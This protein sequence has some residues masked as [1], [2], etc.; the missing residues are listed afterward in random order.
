MT[1]C[2]DQSSQT[3]S[4]NKV[5]NPKF[6]E[7]MC[8]LARLMKVLCNGFPYHSNMRCQE[9]NWSH[10]EYDI[11][12]EQCAPSQELNGAVTRS[13]RSARKGARLVA[14]LTARSV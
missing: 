5:H 8:F 12:E 13:P 1:P 6:S 10:F 3:S 2:F 14:K 7:A 4:L 9:P 11:V